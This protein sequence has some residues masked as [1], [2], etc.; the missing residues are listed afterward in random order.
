MPDLVMICQ[1]W[2]KKMAADL[3]T[4]FQNEAFEVNI[5]KANLPYEG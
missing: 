5:S 1:L 3:G 2:P 4:V